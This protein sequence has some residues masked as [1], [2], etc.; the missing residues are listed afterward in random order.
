MKIFLC[1]FLGLLCLTSAR[2]ALS[3]GPFWCRD[4]ERG[5]KSDKL[6]ANPVLVVNPDGSIL[7]FKNEFDACSEYSVSSYY[8]LRT[9][10]K[11]VKKCTPV[12]VSV[13][14]LTQYGTLVD[15]RDECAAAEDQVSHYFRGQ[16]PR[17]LDQDIIYCA[18]L[19]RPMLKI[20][21][22]TMYRPICAKL[23][24]GKYETRDACAPCNHADVISYV[25]GEC[26]GDD[27]QNQTIEKPEP[28]L[29]EPPLI[30][31]PLPIGDPI[32]IPEPHILVPES[33]IITPQPVIE[34][35]VPVAEAEPEIVI[36]Y[37]APPKAVEA[38]PEETNVE[39]PIMTIQPIDDTVSIDDAPISFAP[40]VEEPKYTILPIKTK[41]IILTA[42]KNNKNLRRN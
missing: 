7:T 36:C 12:G 22:I 3:D 24:T 10:P 27:H 35:P 6:A 8:R 23:V 14:G 29:V 37:M 4:S 38:L 40:D 15:Y 1:T 21:C 2:V 34:K 33:E 11:N 41:P 31:R 19:P 39:D 32:F 16:C 30:M 25:N 13:C 20:M 17:A 28:V 26:P 9:T 5:I 18:P 42:N